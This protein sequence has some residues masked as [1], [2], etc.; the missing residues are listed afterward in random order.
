[1]APAQGLHTASFNL[2]QDQPH[3]YAPSLPNINHCPLLGST[4]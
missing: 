4:R 1:M 3:P 2:L